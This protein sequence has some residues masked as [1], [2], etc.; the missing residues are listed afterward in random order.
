MRHSVRRSDLP[1]WAPGVIVALALAAL[2]TGCRGEGTED[3][4][5]HRVQ[6][7]TAPTPPIV[8]PVR[9]LVTIL[10]EEGAAVSGAVVTVEG[11]MTH[12]GMVPVLEAAEEREDGHYLISS[13]EFAM[14]GD[15]ILT[16]RAELPDGRE[17][18]RERQ[19]R[20]VGDRP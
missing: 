19:V 15:W 10:D 18:R 4:L 12:A 14:G 20:V 17:L 13:F 5:P 8:G 11:T 7:S 2:L 6:V 16:V 1:T 9:M 3:D